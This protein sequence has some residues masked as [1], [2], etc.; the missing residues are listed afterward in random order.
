M[1][2]TIPG[3][4]PDKALKDIVRAEQQR[5][6]K[7]NFLLRDAMRDLIASGEKYRDEESKRVQLLCDYTLLRIK[8]RLIYAEEYN[9]AL[10]EIMKDTVPTLEEGDKVYRLTAQEK[11]NINEATIKELVKD[12]KKGLPQF[13]KTYA[14]TPWA[15]MAQREQAVVLGLAWRSAKQ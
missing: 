8:S 5:I 11:I 1:R 14:D 2:Q 10:A 13:V 6:G 12:V 3:K 4:P 9:F 15:V 7:L